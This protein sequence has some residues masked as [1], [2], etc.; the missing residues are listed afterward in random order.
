MKTLRIAFAFLLF[1]PV[2]AYSATISGVPAGNYSTNG[3]F[4][5]SW[6]FGYLLRQNEAAYFITGG[7]VAQYQF[8]NL[9]SGIYRFELFSCMP[10]SGS[11]QDP[12]CEVDQQSIV[13]I[14]VERHQ[15]PSINTSTAEAG[16]IE[17][18]A[19][20]TMRGSA[21]IDVPIQITDGVNG[22]APNL[23]LTYDSTR[24]A[25]LAEVYFRDDDLG[26][27]WR[28]N[29]LS[30]IHRCRAGAAG[31]P[32]PTL[33]DSDRLCLDGEELV[34]T[35]GASYW[36][37]GAVYRTSRQS[38]VKVTK[39]PNNWFEAK[40]PDGRIVKYGDT[41][42]S[43]VVGGGIYDGSG[44]PTNP[45][46]TVYIWGERHSTNGFGDV[47]TVFYE[48]YGPYGRLQPKWITYPNATVEFRYSPISDGERKYFALPTGSVGSVTQSAKLHTIRVKGDGKLTREYRLDSNLD[49]S[50]RERLE[51][52]Q[53]CGYDANGASPKCL[54]P[55][56]VD[57]TEPANTGFDQPILVSKITNGFGASTEFLYE[58]LAPGNGG[59]P[60]SFSQRPFGSFS[61]SS[62]TS[63][64]TLTVVK[65]VK[66]SNGIAS[67]ATRSWD[68][69]YT[70][71]ALRSTENRGIF[72][73]PQVLRI[74]ND[75]N[76][77]TD[78][79]TYTQ[80]WM[81][82]DF[83]G[84]VSA[85]RVFAGS[86]ISA[87]N[88]IARHETAYKKRTYFSGAVTTPYVDT[89]TVWRFEDGVQMGGTETEIDMCFRPL[90]GDSCGTGSLK[91][92]ATQVVTTSKTGKTISDD[93]NWVT[94]IWGEVQ[95][96]SI[97]GVQKTDTVTVNYQSD[98]S[99]WVVR[100]PV[101][102][103][104]TQLAAGESSVSKTDTYSYVPGTKSLLNNTMFPG[105]PTLSL[106]VARQYSGNN[107]SKQ[108]VSG[109]D[110]STRE[111]DI[112]PSAY[113]FDRYP[114]ETSDALNHATTYDWDIR[115]GKVSTITDNDQQS[116]EYSWD[117]F[118]RLESVLEE[119]GTKTTYK[120]QRC[121]LSWVDCSVVAQ[122]VPAMRIRV[123]K[124]HGTKKVAP[125]SDTY[126]DILG[127]EVLR[128]V[129][130]LNTAEG[131]RRVR[132]VY[133]QMG[134][135]LYVSRPYFSTESI[136]P[137]CASSQPK[138]KCTW[139]EYD[140]QDRVIREDRPDGGYTTTEF[141]ELNGD[142]TVLTTEKIKVPG[143]S[144]FETR[145][146]KAFFNTLGEAIKTVDADGIASPVTSLYDYTSHGYLENV[147]INWKT[148]A[149]MLYDAAGYRKQI[150][151]LSMGIT[152]F[153]M[154]A[155]GELRSS[156]DAR[157]QRTD[158]QYDLLG[159][160]LQ[161]TD[162]ATDVPGRPKVVN[163]WSWDPLGHTGLLSSVS[164]PGYTETFT[165]RT[166]DSKLEKVDTAINVAGINETFT[167]EYEY[168]AWGRL[169]KIIYPNQ[170]IRHEYSGR[171][172][173]TK[174]YGGGALRHEIVDTDAF[175]NVEFEN[176]N[177][178]VTRTL[179]TYGAEMGRL[180]TVKTGTLQSNGDLTPS[181]QN[182]E[183]KWRSDG[184]LHQ[185]LRKN[186]YSFPLAIDE[187]TYD[188]HGRIKFQSTTDNSG[189]DIR[190]RNFSYDIYGNLKA[191]SS[192]VAGDADVFSYSYDS[193]KIHRLN[194]VKIRGVLNTLSYDNNG[195]IE[196]YT[197]AGDNT[198]IK[199][200][201]LNRVTEVNLAASET[202][203]P[204][205][206]DEFWYSPDGNRFL[207]RATWDDGGSQSQA[208]TV[209]LGRYEETRPAQGNK[210]KI[211]RI[212]ASSAVQFV[213]TSFTSGSVSSKWY[214][215]HRDEMGSVTA[216]D[217]GSGTSIDK[218]EFDPF[219]T[220]RSEDWASDIGQAALTAILDS[221]FDDGAR[222]YTD[223]EMLDRTGFIHMN[224]RVFD[225]RIG[226]FLS[227]D[228]I[229]QFP[230]FSQSY[231][232][233][234]YV[235][236]QP[237]K[238]VDPTGFKAGDDRDVVHKG[239]PPPNPGPP[240]GG[241]TFIQE[242]VRE[243]ERGDRERERQA[244]GG[245]WALSNGYSCNSGG[246]ETFAGAA[247]GIVGNGGGYTSA[248][249]GSLER[250]NEVSPPIDVVRTSSFT[251]N[252]DFHTTIEFDQN[253]YSIYSDPSGNSVSD[254]VTLRREVTKLPSINV[255]LPAGSLGKYGRAALMT[256]E[257]AI[258]EALDLRQ[259]NLLQA[260]VLL[261]D[262]HRERYVRTFVNHQQTSSRKVREIPDGQVWGFPADG[263]GRYSET[264]VILCRFS[265]VFDQC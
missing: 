1:A 17:Y 124:L 148:V 128:S 61:S 69:R 88:E 207:G 186:I 193:A 108:T 138:T 154:N 177:N 219:G 189:N 232:R 38:S 196:Q 265:S 104:T 67:G 28:L 85:R 149:T 222:G 37:T 216:I 74:E 80:I 161:R 87:S 51:R 162:N 242:L 140:E 215:L 200:D 261:Y 163:T 22:H 201:A 84:F 174:Y 167:R 60:I 157:G 263:L 73:F 139:Y 30:K 46:A 39:K 120:Y 231:N 155:L 248:D 33:S 262:K 205:A 147:R 158:Y 145:T 173:L 260:Q 182:I 214:Y 190:E 110:F 238:F 137:A 63:E 237:K 236:N 264:N 49:G 29:G 197:A 218:R 114:G 10:P 188:T 151:E 58:T 9:P 86:S 25:D 7:T 234:S 225:S 254:I 18:T 176:F 76:T 119:D 258:S 34:R 95:S 129:E 117:R 245:C 57:W 249:L 202:A 121:D 170:T 21:K 239:D 244:R 107:V 253:R 100:K 62:T 79:H 144:T 146:K 259:E 135:V 24:P 97:G 221:E 223:H 118:G 132:T 226:R 191:N 224:G 220:R 153:D 8:V 31:G 43:K 194:T 59:N 159:R 52:V 227:P 19:D 44:D 251:L 56:V 27:G 168:D 130:A 96:R 70:T 199:Y 112:I 212:Q 208:T 47:Y 142:Y 5:L 134:R 11:Q 184:A 2:L 246:Y 192:D 42:K 250:T 36:D 6:P 133:D 233:Y 198:Y 229:V 92:F 41:A 252:G 64:T 179:R 203:A 183:A 94:F 171:G 113:Q 125:I 72:G 217:E 99:P 247:R 136:I 81:S 109:V 48:V 93:P 35:S 165:Y 166:S 66:R 20:T 106:T 187:F 211:Q 209:Y 40:Y 178:G 53:V 68:Y 3:N 127:R 16:T 257:F 152:Q 82:S 102:K 181:I 143:S 243:I 204:T 210:S 156:T 123:E 256:L 111:T 77:T 115:F 255:S 180:L 71:G 175:G 235:L 213:R 160:L 14:T 103:I 83:R 90:V 116:I 55:L 122:A 26:Y 4:T 131:H 15:E 101:K 12:S 150:D 23:S 228:P 75:P 13:E 185:R 169:E 54:K 78:T 240:G 105:D 45:N 230:M 164:N 65:Q 141:G 241:D 50:A 89:H 126:L 98:S 206:K 32:V 172:Y 195:N 91:E